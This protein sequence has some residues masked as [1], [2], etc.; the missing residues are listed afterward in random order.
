MAWGSCDCAL[1]YDVHSISLLVL[2]LSQ[3]QRYYIL[4]YLTNPNQ[5]LTLRLNCHS[6]YRERKLALLSVWLKTVED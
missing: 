2:D 4:K 6:K 3:S 1:L 5:H